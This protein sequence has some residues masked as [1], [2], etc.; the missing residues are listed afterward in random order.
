VAAIL[1]AGEHIGHVHASASHRGLLGKD[2]V[3]WSGVIGALLDIGY[4]G[5]VVIESFSEDNKVIA[6]AAAVWRPLYDSPEQLA[7]EGLAFL[8][9]E[10]ERASRGVRQA[11]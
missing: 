11:I 8:R 1:K 4:E 2:Q 10:L 7:V 3:D 6:R 5:D 9:N